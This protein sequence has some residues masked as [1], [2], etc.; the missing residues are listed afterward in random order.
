MKFKYVTRTLVIQLLNVHIYQDL[1]TDGLN[2][3]KAE[4]ASRGLSTIKS[5]HHLFKKKIVL[6]FWP[7]LNLNHSV[8]SSAITEVSN[9]LYRKKVF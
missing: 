4:F 1:L 9:H 8:V 3:Y 6:L 7:V 5:T 2:F